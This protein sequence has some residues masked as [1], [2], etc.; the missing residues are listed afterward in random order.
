METKPIT[1]T[2]NR[3]TV[4]NFTFY[5]T[6]VFNTTLTL[7]RRMVA[8]LQAADQ[9]HSTATL[10]GDLLENCFITAQTVQKNGNT[11]TNLS[12]TLKKDYKIPGESEKKQPEG[13]P[14]F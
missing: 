3:R 9:L 8:A 14:S 11:Y 6:T 7:S 2:L 10:Q 1:L 13:A 4:G 12:L 5:D